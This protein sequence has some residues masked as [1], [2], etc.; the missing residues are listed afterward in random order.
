[1]RP[2]LERVEQPGDIADAR[3]RGV[4]TGA[5]YVIEVVLE[6]ETDCSMGAALDAIREFA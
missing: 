1:M 2:A 4:E 5:P 3:A 6:Q